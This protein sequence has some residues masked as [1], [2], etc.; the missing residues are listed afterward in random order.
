VDVIDD[1]SASSPAQDD[2]QE[3]DLKEENSMAITPR[4]TRTAAIVAVGAVSAFGLAA[5][6]S[7]DSG[8]S[9]ASGEPITIEYLHRL[10][11]GEGMTPASEI[12]D[13]W[14]AEHPD[15]QVKAT[16]F[17]G[18]SSDMILKL[19]T[20]VKAGN[21]PCLAQ[22][23]YSEVP[24]LFVKG[25]LQDVADEAKKYEDDF[26]AGAFSGMKVGDAIVGLPQDTGPLVYFYNEAEFQALGLDV[27]KTLDDLTAD[28]ATAAAAGKYV[29]AFTPDEAQNWLSAQSAAAGDTW[30]T[31]EGDEW[32]VDAEGAGSE[33][34][35]GFWQGLLDNKQ[36]LATERWGEGFTAALNDGSLIGH[37]GAAWEAGFLLDSLD[38]TPA[39]GQWRVAQLPD[40]G[41]GAHERPRRRLRRLG[42]EGLRA[43]RRGDGVQRLVQ[44]AGRRPRLAGTRRRR[45]GR[46]W[47][48]R[49]RCCA[50]SADRMCSPSSPRR[51]RT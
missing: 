12:V 7:G 51:P 37:V 11:D 3:H 13:R 48:R 43:P 9:G 14:N 16:K 46:A 29:T 50:S 28:S 30:F 22:T 36:T 25:L 32:K 40:L 2:P 5:C 23:G 38:G 26:S 34:V 18:K 4:F 17:D 47:R 31:T 41:A 24:Q 19:E 8:D 44:H 20:D 6:S 39:E 21:G 10:P 42:D 35:A 1:A 33:R 27:P 45:E 49:R 15:I